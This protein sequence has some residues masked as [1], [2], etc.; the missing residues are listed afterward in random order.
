MSCAASAKSFTALP[1]LPLL[2]ATTLCG[3]VVDGS[4]PAP[5]RGFRDAATAAQPSLHVPSPDWRDQIIYF[6]MIDRFNDGDRS[7]NDQGANEFDPTQNAKYS[8]GDLA[9]LTQRLDYIKGLGATAL[10]ITPP[11][12]H[13]WWDERNQY[14]GYHGYW[15]EHFM[16]VDP[17]FGTL[18][19]YQQLSAQLHAAGMYLVQDIVVN[20]LGNYFSYPQDWS[21]AD[22]IAGFV[23]NPDRA[24]RM[25][26][27]QWPFSQNDVR[28]PGQRQAGIY[29]WTPTIVD[30][31]NVVHEQT[32]QLADLDDLNTENAS[33]RAAL[34][35]SYGYWIDQVGVDAYR[36]DTAFHV[37]EH[38]FS[39]FLHSD[40]ALHPG[41]VRVAERSGRSQFHVFGEGFGADRPYADEQA[42]KINRYLRDT[43]GN[44][45]LPGMINFPLYG[46][47]GD[48]FA[49]GRPTA[50]LGYR[51]RS[52]MQ[53][54]PRPH[55][56][57][58]FIDN[59]DVDRFLSGG[60]AAALKQSLLLTMTLPGIPTLYY[61][62]EQGFTEPRGAMFADGFKAGGRDHFDTNAPL[63]R[64]IQSATRLRRTQPVF[65]RGTPEIL[66][67]NAAA[68]GAFVYRMRYEGR[69]ALVM[70]NSSDS[71]TLLD[72]LDTGMAPGT[73]LKGVFGIHGQPDD[74][75]VSSDGRLN[76]QLAARSGQV[77]LPSAATQS[78]PA[79][80]APPTNDQAQLILQPLSA[81]TMSDDF[82]VEGSAVGI[83]RAQL[84]VDGDLARAQPI[85]IDGAGRWRAKID[86][87]SMIDASVEH[88]VVAWDAVSGSV[89]RR[90]NFRVARVWTALA[91]Q[92]DPAGDDSGPQGRYRYPSDPGWGA[93][94]QLDIRRVRVLGSA[95]A[96]R[97]ELAMN[98]VSAGWKPANG[99]DHVAFTLCFQVPG[100]S[101]GSSVLPLQNADLPAGLRWHYRLRAHGWS[102]A[103]F[104]AGGVT[105][106]N[107]GTPITP[108]ADIHVDR[109]ANT[110]TF[111]LPSASLGGL[112]SLSGVNI[113][114]N[115]WDYD[116]G[117]KPL[118]PNAGGQ[119]FSGGDGAVDPLVMDDMVIEIL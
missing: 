75:M 28:L 71:A 7:N 55:L 19:D 18:H 27:T 110:V 41:I 1:A 92:V 91:D 111:T 80:S 50:E 42:R 97:V 64:F 33:V 53:L 46:T 36:V 87:S 104:A 93:N 25:A 68:A 37:P 99:F 61:G 98:Q 63:Y 51:I 48:V 21:A 103:L 83:A 82:V 108:N 116:A 89:S 6:A 115:T 47:I 58:T 38:F 106:S 77:W 88:S 39:D 15:G 23:L 12:R 40:D 69:S 13:R 94:H 24:G 32:Y 105:R 118:S 49:R 73:V 67:E 84:V 22:P 102:N 85:T 4:A 26:P 10:W 112:R 59:H 90:S 117:Y 57:P 8:G 3:C 30:H 70:F 9:G 29:H 54:H 76:L 72:N 35:Q 60:S 100:Q 86:T 79:R 107:E 56:M 66:Y 78:A 114:I 119:G 45:L 34:R 109:D 62:T 95:G 17:H 81:G 101:G 96:L 11:V 31:A 113:Y 43:D 44:D 20:H 2:I 16:E 5:Q 74:L 65:S 52:M 14:G